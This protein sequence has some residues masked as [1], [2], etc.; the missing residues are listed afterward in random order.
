MPSVKIGVAPL[1]KLLMSLKATRSLTGL[2]NAI[3]G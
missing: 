1:I 3:K 2:T